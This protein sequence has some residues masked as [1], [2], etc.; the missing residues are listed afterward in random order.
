M[1]FFPSLIDVVAATALTL[2]VIGAWVRV[3]A[4]QYRRK[5][6]PKRVL[7]EPEFTLRHVHKHNKKTADG[8]YLCECGDRYLDGN[9]KKQ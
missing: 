1:D 2:S 8:I 4:W 6:N 5:W 9:P 3:R 7:I